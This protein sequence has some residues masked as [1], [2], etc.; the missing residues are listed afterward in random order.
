M[1][2]DFIKN[3]KKSHSVELHTLEDT[4]QKDTVPLGRK[5]SFDS[6]LN[7][8]P[9]LDSFLGRPSVV[10]DYNPSLQRLRQEECTFWS[11]V[12]YRKIMGER[13]STPLLDE[14]MTVSKHI[15]VGNEHQPW[16][17]RKKTAYCRSASFT[18]GLG[19][20]PNFIVKIFTLYNQE[21]F[22]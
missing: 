11:N 12:S 6:E 22:S 7:R 3:L 21:S 18:S 20:Y 14:L 15:S 10:Q 13:K 1:H 16:R 9:I 2:T 19:S 17:G 4:V 5:T 8:F